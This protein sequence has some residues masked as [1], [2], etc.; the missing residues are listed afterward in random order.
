M[1]LRVLLL[2]LVGLAAAAQGEPRG[3]R[4]EPV[5]LSRYSAVYYVDQQRGDDFQGNGS[6][7][8]PWESLMTALESVGTAGSTQ[9]VAVLVSHGRYA[10]PT[11]VLKPQVDLF[12][13]FASPGGER[14]IYAYAT[15]LDG[16]DNFRIAIGANDARV[17]GFHFVRGRVRGKG[18]ALLCDGTS[19][20]I[21]NCVFT[22]NRTLAPDNWNPPLLHERANDG[23]AVM[24]LNGAAPVFENCYFFDNATECGRGGALACDRQASPRIT[25]CVFA[26]NRAGLDDPM[27]SSDG[28]AIS[29]FDG[30]RPELVGNVVVANEALA[31]ND[32]GGIFVALW[33]SPRIANSVIVGN[34]G[35]DDAGG[36]FIGGQEHRYDAPFDAFPPA[37]KFNVIVERNVFAGNANSWTN[38]GALRITM[39]ARVRLA[40]NIIAANKGGLA[41]ER[42]EITAERNTVWQDWRFLEA[43]LPPGSSVFTGNVLKGPAGVISTNV[44]FSGNMVSA[45]VPGNDNVGV[46]DIFENDGIKGD[47]TQ[48]RFDAASMTT[49]V[50]TAQPLPAGN[51]AGRVVLISNGRKIGQWRVIKEASGSSLVVWGRL[52]AVTKPETHFEILRTFRLRSDAPAGLGAMLN[53]P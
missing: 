21:A 41:L 47:I 19:P 23:G 31:R 26:N 5:D 22:R 25:G 38:S 46:A 1:T 6:R 27:R 28:G 51:L 49:H 8:Q 17:D 10:Q 42:S 29:I 32:A 30:S 20:V 16:E 12:G 4:G 18:A 9:R 37:D 34:E 3:P 36:L 53:K 40:H 52:R 43:K 35:G 15:Q 33:S 24:C 11:F 50:I 45:D 44:G 48:M 14:D 13:G 39:E 7:E 2:V